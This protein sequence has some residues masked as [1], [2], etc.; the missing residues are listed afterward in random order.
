MSFEEILFMKSKG[1]TTLISKYINAKT[2]VALSCVEG[3]IWNVIPSNLVSKGSGVFCRLCV[4]KPKA[5]KKSQEDFLQEMSIKH[6]SIHVLGTY[7]GANTPIEIACAKGHTRSVTPTNLLTRDSY[8]TCP[9]C[10]PRTSHNRLT[11]EEAEARIHRCYPHLS[12]VEYNT[13]LSPIRILN[14]ECGH[15]GEYWLS[16][17]VQDRGYACKICQP[18]G[19]SSHEKTISEYIKSIYKGWIVERDRSILGN[20][21]LDI[22]LP[23]LGIAFEVNGCFWHADNKKPKDYHLGKTNDVEDFGY[24]L[25]HIYDYDINNKLDI[26]KSR[27]RSILDLTTTVFARK[28]QVKEINFPKQFLMDNHIQG[29]GWPTPINL[30]LFL[31]DE[32]VAVMTFGKSRNHSTYEYELYRYCSILDVTVVGGASKLLKHFERSYTPKS[33]MSYAD[34]DWSNGNLYNA[35]GFTFSHYS[36]PGYFYINNNHKLGRESTKKHLLKELFPSIYEDSKT[37]TQILEEAQYLRVNTSGNLIFFKE[38]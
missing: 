26:V 2:S 14:T 11:L 13:S 1:A 22:V 16:N 18:A 29:A 9:I 17:L 35:L 5:G 10:S 30:G 20:K 36:P 32:L 6:P 25:I 37:E 15:T 3:H 38:Y 4:G 12:I 28:C 8:S 33:L 7:L 19:T 24:R 23:D 21:E 27:I 34:R 31:K